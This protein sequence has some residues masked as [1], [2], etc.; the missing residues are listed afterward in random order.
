M[1]LRI[2]ELA[3]AIGV[4]RVT[5]YRWEADGFVQRPKHP[6][7]YLAEWLVALPETELLAVA[8]LVKKHEK[9]GTLG[10]CPIELYAKMNKSFSAMWPNAKV[11]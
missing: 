10:R 8:S 6:A 3:V 5:L 7:A 2:E 4:H 11:G 1:G 9:R